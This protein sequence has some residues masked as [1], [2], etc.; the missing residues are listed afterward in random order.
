MKGIQFL[1]DENGSPKSVV[2]DLKEHAKIWESIYDDMV[3]EGNSLIGCNLSWKEMKAEIK[4]N[5][6][7]ERAKYPD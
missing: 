7:R 2:I 3:E 6:E 1:V 5:V 4:A